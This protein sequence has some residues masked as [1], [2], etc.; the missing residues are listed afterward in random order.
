M[1]KRIVMVAAMWCL[2]SLGNAEQPAL[3]GLDCHARGLLAL[4]LGAGHPLMGLL[5]AEP[6]CPG[7][8]LAWS[9]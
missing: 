1:G 8:A 5:V 3:A 9:R 7:A 2:S 6:A 4:H